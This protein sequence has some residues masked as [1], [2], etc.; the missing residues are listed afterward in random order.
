M[1]RLAV[2][3][4]DEVAGLDPGPGGRRVVDRRDDLDQAV[5]HGDLDAEAAELAPGLHLHVAVLLGVEIARMRIERGQHA[6]DRRLDQRLVAD[7]L[8]IF[9]AD[10]LEDVAEQLELRGTCRSSAD[11]V[12]PLAPDMSVAPRAA[13][14]S[15][16]AVVLSRFARID[17]APCFALPTG[18][19]RSPTF[20]R[21]MIWDEPMPDAVADDAGRTFQ[22]E[23]QLYPE[24][25]Q[26]ASPDHV[27]IFLQCDHDQG[28]PAAAPVCGEMKPSATAGRPGIRCSGSGLP[29][30]GGN[31]ARAPPSGVPACGAMVGAPRHN[32]SRDC[33]AASGSLAGNDRSRRCRNRSSCRR[34]ARA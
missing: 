16:A 28:R 31:S 10:P 1:H 29:T 27:M 8:D 6:V 15:T 20:R 14:T 17:Y 21:T 3:L 18:R 12:C 13:P 2:D 9:G 25:S 22:V 4:G 19:H 24:V 30:D 32:I 7:L 33:P 5:L 34:S 26:G 23:V 11:W